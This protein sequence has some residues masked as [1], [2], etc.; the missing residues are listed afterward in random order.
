[1]LSNSSIIPSEPESQINNHLEILEECEELDKA[2]PQTFTKGALKAKHPFE[3]EF[4]PPLFSSMQSLA[5][6][7][8]IKDIYA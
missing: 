2:E 4:L 1:M 5:S 8:N 3:L 7:L 6:L